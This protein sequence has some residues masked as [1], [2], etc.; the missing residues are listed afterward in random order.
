MNSDYTALTARRALVH[1]IHRFVRALEKVQ[2]PPNRREV[3]YL[4]Q[5]LQCL[6]EGTYEDGEAAMLDAERRAPLPPDVSTSP[7]SNHVVT[8]QEI[9]DA[10]E[11]LMSQQ[12][13]PTADPTAP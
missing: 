2:R 9:R 13:A 10:L 6:N 11:A 12:P 1:R 4:T 5:A 7:Q 3:Y 8:A